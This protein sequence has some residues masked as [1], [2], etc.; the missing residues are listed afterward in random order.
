MSKGRFFCPNCGN[1]HDSMILCKPHI[2][3]TPDHTDLVREL[4]EA[5]GEANQFIS[6]GVELGY[7]R[8]P[9]KNTIDSALDTQKTIRQSLTKAREAGF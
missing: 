9:D 4:V 6:N 2:T 8:L 3:E 7:I 1:A 5:L